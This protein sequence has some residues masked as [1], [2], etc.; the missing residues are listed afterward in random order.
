MT[1]LTILCY[2][3]AVGFATMAP[4]RPAGTL[5]ARTADRLADLIVGGEWK[6]REYLPREEELTRRLGVSRTAYREA[7]CTLEAHGLVEVRLGIGTRVADRST[8]AIADSLGLLLRRR[9]SATTDLLET[10]H[11]LETEAAALAAQRATAADL[12]ALDAALDAMRR[13]TASPEDYVAGDV[14]FHLALALASGN[15]VLATPTERRRRASSSKI[16][17]RVGSPRSP[18]PVSP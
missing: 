10:R 13:P 17:R 5:R 4:L 7:M 9:R 8:E 14:K 15:A 6:P 3:R 1:Y 12:L 16:A 2:S 18:R 11:I